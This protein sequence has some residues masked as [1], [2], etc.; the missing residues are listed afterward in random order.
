[1]QQRPDHPGLLVLVFFLLVLPSCYAT[2]DDMNRQTHMPASA[3]EKLIKSGNPPTI[4]DV[5]SSYEFNQGHV[6]GAIHMPFWQSLSQAD[7]L[8]ASK[9]KPVVVYCAHG[10]RAGIGKFALR[11]AGFTN[12]LYLEGHMTAWKKAGRPVETTAAR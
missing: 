10:P 11:R 1:M 5:R 7:D 3:L 2:G 4:I 12:I 9:D 6:P 8:T